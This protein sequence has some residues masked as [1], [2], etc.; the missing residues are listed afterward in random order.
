MTRLLALR[1]APTDWN[2]SGQL[3]GRADRPLSPLGRSTAATWSLPPFAADWPVFCSPLKR[4]QQTAVLMRLRPGIEPALIEMDWGAWEG[5][6]LGEL[7]RTGGEDFARIE[8]AG[9]DLQPPQGESPRAVAARLS[10]WL[11]GLVRDSV[12]IAHKGV[13]RA[14]VHL[15]TGWSFEGK[16]P[17]KAPSG[18]ALLFH[19][20]AGSLRVEPYAYSLL[21][22][23]RDT[24]SG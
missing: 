21:P 12:A 18:T 22:P 6:N 15:A 11:E 8:A 9:L 5:R 1:H 13:L 16:I 20:E 14:L 23:R 2:E 17:V 4:A 24:S 19:R 7:R 10:T 3:Q